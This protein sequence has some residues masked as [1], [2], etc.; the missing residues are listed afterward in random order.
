MYTTINEFLFPVFL[1]AVYFC[2]VSLLIYHPQSLSIVKSE[3]P[4][5]SSPSYSTNDVDNSPHIEQLIAES[6]EVSFIVE[7]EDI[8]S[9]PAIP[10]VQKGDILDSEPDNSLYIQTETII[11]NLNKRQIRKL[12]NPLGIQQKC[13]E[14]EKSLTFIKAEIRGFFKSD[15]EKVIVVIREKLPE[16]IRVSDEQ[17]SEIAKVIAS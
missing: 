4:E 6:E 11:D 10:E 14:V 13:G 15:P 9:E 1:F 12:C 16:L 17:A 5:T 8:S 7:N 3:S 2:A